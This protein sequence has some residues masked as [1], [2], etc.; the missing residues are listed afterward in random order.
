MEVALQTFQVVKEKE[1]CNEVRDC[2]EELSKVRRDS[3]LISKKGLT[4]EVPIHTCNNP[5]SPLMQP[6]HKNERKG[7]LGLEP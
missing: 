5:K 7:S 6:Q 2:G 1:K 4:T 3:I